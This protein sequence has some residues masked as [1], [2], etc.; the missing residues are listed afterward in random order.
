MEQ[1]LKGKRAVVV[2][3]SRGIGRAV[4]ETL[5]TA[6]A[7]VGFSYVRDEQAAKAVEEQ[8]RSGGGLALAVRADSTRPEQVT[9]LFEA[10]GRYGAPD[11][12]VNVAGTARFGPIA[13]TRDEDLEAQLALNTRGAFYVLR[14][15]A[16]RVAPGGRIIQVST[17]GTASPTAGAGTY[18]ATKAAG[19]HLA[20]ALARELGAQ[21]VTVNVISP[22]L[23][24]TDGLVMPAPAIA[25]MVGQTPLGRLGQGADI[26]DA[27]LFLASEGGRWVT[28]HN[29][30]VTGG[31]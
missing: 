22:G 27:V 31:L 17:G 6:G 1:A 2:G 25:H 15:A 24:E 23:T 7:H 29:L 4:V 12:V 10:V 9:A 8:V 21:K 20:F 14:E 19:E 16:R 11:I 26:A 28:G 5:A 3:G 13:A 18:L 30:R